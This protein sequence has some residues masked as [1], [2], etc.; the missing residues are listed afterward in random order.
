MPF[1]CAS[2][3][4]TSSS[5]AQPTKQPSEGPAP[6]LKWGVTPKA[7]TA[8]SND[9]AKDSK[10]GQTDGEQTPDW[11]NFY[12]EEEKAKLRAK[13]VNPAL[14]AEMETRTRA[15][16]REGKFWQKVAGTAMGGGWIK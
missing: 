6:G 12:S 13:G 7:P 11:E 9:Q 4:S 16:G 2:N 1:N 15:N 14:K 5:T 8:A 3:K 10:P